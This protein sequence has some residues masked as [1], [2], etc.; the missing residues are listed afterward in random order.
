MADLQILHDFLPPMGLIGVEAFSFSWNLL[1]IGLF[2]NCRVKTQEKTA[3]KL[4]S[5]TKAEKSMMP[6]EKTIKFFGVTDRQR[7]EG[8]HKN[9]IS[10]QTKTACRSRPL[11]APSGCLAAAARQCPDSA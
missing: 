9:E 8:K 4:P 3:D 1:P 6:S 11:C 7:L 5:I 2:L 10:P